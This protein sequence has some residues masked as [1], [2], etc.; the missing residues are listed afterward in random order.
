MYDVSKIIIYRLQEHLKSSK[1]ELFWGI[2]DA[3]GTKYGELS[4]LL[5][6]DNNDIKWR[7]GN[8]IISRSKLLTMEA[9]EDK[10]LPIYR[11]GP[12]WI[13]SSLSCDFINLT[14][15]EVYYGAF[16]GALFPSMNTSYCDTPVR[17]ILT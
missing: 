1:N 11:K 9:F 8:L 17:I 16:C 4:F 5:R 14:I 7:E 12:S 6:P 3:N 2:L 13:H 15:V 10:I